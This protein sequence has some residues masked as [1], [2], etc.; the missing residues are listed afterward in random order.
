MLLYFSIVK[1]CFRFENYA[2]YN[3]LQVVQHDPCKG[4]AGHWNSLFRFKHL[5]T[6]QYLAAE[7][8]DDETL[9]Q[10][11]SKLR[12]KKSSQV[13]KKPVLLDCVWSCVILWATQ[14]LTELF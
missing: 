4:G 9:D 2:E 3:V 13:R 7:I 10:M 8:D 11:R 5:A 6:G 12:G 14:R 1:L